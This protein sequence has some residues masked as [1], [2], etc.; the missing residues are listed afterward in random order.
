MSTILVTGSTGTVGLAAVKSLASKP[1]VTIRAAFHSRP[2]EIRSDN[3]HP[4]HMD[5]AAAN[6]IRAA[7]A[8]VD[9]VF[10][11]TPPVPGQEEHRHTG[12]RRSCRRR[13]PAHRATFGDRSGTARREIVHPRTCHRGSPHCRIRNPVD[14]PSALQFHV[15]LP[16]VL[17]PR[18]TG[19]PA[20]TRG[21]RPHRLHRPARCRR[22]CGVRSHQHRS[23]R[24]GIYSYRA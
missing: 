5:Y 7:A 22:R 15:Q 8:Q 4:V 19:Q 17:R 10:L 12:L 23:R 2:P 18:Q 21:R 1:G 13:R 16:G 14:I 9:A 3:V 24:T 11:I 6:S 20:A